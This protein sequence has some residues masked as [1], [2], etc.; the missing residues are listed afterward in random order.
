[1]PRCGALIVRTAKTAINMTR[2]EPAHFTTFAYGSNMLTARLRAR[3]PS[4]TAI[5]VGYIAGHALK[6]HKKSRDGSGKC[7]IER[8]GQNGD[9]VWGVLF[10]IAT[11][12]KPALDEAEGFG[13]GYEEQSVEI[14]VGD[15]TLP[16]LA[17][18]ATSKDSSLR[19]YHWYKAFV[20]AGAKEHGL[21][22]AYVDSLEATASIAD[23]DSKRNAKNMR[24]FSSDTRNT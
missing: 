23:P 19:P 22:V 14:V 9:V 5:G 24:I 13:A 2:S 10:K 11:A 20:V 6:W 15:S 21:P 4:A 1:M 8:T 7:D 16:A 17:Y 3:V 18:V 12:E